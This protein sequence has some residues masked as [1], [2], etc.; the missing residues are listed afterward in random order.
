MN[1]PNANL[2]TNI[3]SVISRFN[4]NSDSV[5]EVR[6]EI[7]LEEKKAEVKEIIN[8][9]LINL[10]SFNELSRLEKKDP[11]WD[12]VFAMES[13]LQILKFC[14]S[15][16]IDPNKF[17]KW[18]VKNSGKITCESDINE[19]WKDIKSVHDHKNHTHVQT[20]SDKEH[21]KHIHSNKDLATELR[22]L[23][24]E[25][26]KESVLVPLDIKGWSFNVYQQFLTSGKVGFRTDKI[27]IPFAEN[28]GGIETDHSGRILSVSGAEI[29]TNEKEKPLHLNNI[30]RLRIAIG[31]VKYKVVV[32]NRELFA[33]PLVEKNQINGNSKQ[34][35]Q[36]INLP[37]NQK[38]SFPNQERVNDN[39]KKTSKSSTFI[40]INLSKSESISS[41][42]YLAEDLE[43]RIPKAWRHAYMLLLA[44]EIQNNPQ[45]FK[46]EIIKERSF[47]G[48][49]SKFTTVINEAPEELMRR[50]EEMEQVI[51]KYF[52]L[53]SDKKVPQ[54]KLQKIKDSGLPMQNT[55]FQIDKYNGELPQTVVNMLVN[56]YSRDPAQTEKKVSEVVSMGRNYNNLLSNILLKGAKKEECV[57]EKERV[58]IEQRL[59]LV[60]SPRINNKDEENIEVTR[61]VSF[62]QGVR[63]LTNISDG[64]IDKY[65]KKDSVLIPNKLVTINPKKLDLHTLSTFGHS[66]TGTTIHHDDLF[67]VDSSLKGA[68]KTHLGTFSGKT[69]LNRSWFN[70]GI[71]LN[72]E[73]P[74]QESFEVSPMPFATF[75]K[76]ELKIGET[77]SNLEFKLSPE[78]EASIGTTI[79]NFELYLR[80]DK[81]FGHENRLV[82]QF[83]FNGAKLRAY[84]SYISTL[85][86]LEIP[87][88]IKEL[89]NA[90]KTN[91]PKSPSLQ[92]VYEYIFAEDF[93]ESNS[94]KEDNSN[95]IKKLIK[96]YTEQVA[97]DLKIEE[98]EKKIKLFFAIL[99]QVILDI[100]KYHNVRKADESPLKITGV[101]WS[102]FSEGAYSAFGMQPLINFDKSVI[103]SYRI[104]ETNQSAT[105]MKNPNLI[106][107]SE[108]SNPSIKY[109]GTSISAKTMTPVSYLFTKMSAFGKKIFSH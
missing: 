84:N 19:L 8:P 59:R 52:D 1:V 49:K 38:A 92:R 98:P 76:H 78:I 37:Q 16:G 82:V 21:L 74:P 77:S 23:F 12:K 61:K 28:I 106:G 48:L 40:D 57:Q 31:G 22:K 9:F 65:F 104:K 5:G 100:E 34:D 81:H 91:D 54:L 18:L 97:Q 103:E 13:Q 45:L 105:S 43:K 85:D 109:T 90:T 42:L 27:K 79:K 99:G 83:V 17:W 44:E 62:A 33:I 29:I 24:K 2:T 14:E 72:A 51:G 108:D 25:L 93:T 50:A 20:D 68:L 95:G 86:T 15:S 73:Q 30:D 88:L 101:Q 64:A 32:K 63:L 10:N 4:Q 102:I 66:H 46:Y 41:K 107:L 39:S 53:N 80:F 56:N 94:L 47:L 11:K 75:S 96:N 26:E 36:E 6:R 3:Q 60:N 67:F 69:F 70:S 89:S 58:K 7:A 87:K 55:I 71:A 35:T